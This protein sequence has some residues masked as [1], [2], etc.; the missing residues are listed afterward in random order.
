MGRGGEEIQAVFG[1]VGG[2]V[3][4]ARGTEGAVDVAQE[5]WG[6]LS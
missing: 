6:R 3:V 4:G 2:Q 5:R 1:V